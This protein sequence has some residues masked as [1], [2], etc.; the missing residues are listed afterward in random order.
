MSAGWRSSR[1]FGVLP[2]LTAVL[3]AGCVAQAEVVRTDQATH[4]A[5][6]Q[7]QGIVP[8]ALRGVWYADDAEGQA[9]CRTYLSID[10]ATVERT[11]SDPLVGAVVVTRQMVHRYSE[12]GEGNFFRIGRARKDPGGAWV[13]SG[14]MFIDVFPGN[15]AEGIDHVE[16]FELTQNGRS[17]SSSDAAGRSFFKCGEV[18]SD[19]YSAQ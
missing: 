4:A 2:A 8:D 14:Q 12:Y 13:L 9:A 11:G 7:G 1:R 6:G 19:L 10:A 17:F 15:D 18:R 16:R 3:V 5:P